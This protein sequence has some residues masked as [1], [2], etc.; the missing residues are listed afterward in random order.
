MAAAAPVRASLAG[1]SGIT[2]GFRRAD[3]EEAFRLKH[4]EPRAC[5]WRPRADWAL[6]Y[7]TPDLY[8]EALV[9]SLVTGDT[10]WL[11][12]GCG[13]HLFPE[14]PRLATRL[15]G[16]CRCLVGVD[17]DDTLDENP[18][19]HER[20][21]RPIE[22]YGGG[23]TFSLVTLRM[24]A[25]HITDPEKTV[26]VLARLTGSGGKVVVFTVSRW[27]PVTLFS[28]LTP[29]ALHHPIKRVLW[30]TEEKD[31][32]PVVYRMNTRKRL[33]ELFGAAG[34]REGFFAYLDDCRTFARFRWL[35]AT[36]LSCRRVLRGVGLN[37]PEH[38]L[39]GVYERVE[40]GRGVRAGDS[41]NGG[42]T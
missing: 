36:E 39:L 9:A 37:Y 6:G 7:F 31:T 11:D 16:R 23:R 13:R 28:R 29:F 19:V 17:P 5:G 15:S 4:G 1:D 27:A 21:K 22:A 34:F 3:L 35:H 18:F 12:V 38:C 42:E 10:V 8:Y 41:H 26:R 20:A 33:R 30:G 14:N 32:F 40:P 25:E 2:P 24:V